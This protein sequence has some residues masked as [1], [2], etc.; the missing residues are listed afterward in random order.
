MFRVI[1]AG[2]RDFSD[3]DVLTKT[4]DRLLS[5]VT[6]D[7][8]VVCGMA[9]GADSLG[10]KYAIEKNYAVDYHQAEWSKFGGVP[11]IVGMSR[12]QNAQTHL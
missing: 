6:D 2:G 9:R 3:Y 7:I 11:V 1:I 4:M 5:E 10:E 8:T 12:W